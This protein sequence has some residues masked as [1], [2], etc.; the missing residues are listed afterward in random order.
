MVIVMIHYNNII[1]NIENTNNDNAR[2]HHQYHFYHYYHFCITISVTDC[3]I[4]II[5]A[6]IISIITGNFL[7]VIVLLTVVKL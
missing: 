6:Y 1:D 2:Y 4:P 7:N 3:I 5:I